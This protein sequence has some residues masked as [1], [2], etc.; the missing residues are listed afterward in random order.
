[1]TNLKGFKFEIVLVS[2]FK[3]IESEDKYDEFY[4]SSN[5]EI[6]INDSDT[7]GMFQSICTTIITNIRKYL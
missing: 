6:I 3:M 5:A 1:M 4:S 7:D 2:V